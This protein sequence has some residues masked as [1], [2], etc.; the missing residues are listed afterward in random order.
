[1]EY[2]ALDS[3]K[4]YSFASIQDLDGKIRLEARIEHHPGA[5]RELLCKRETGSPVAVE[6]IGNW[7]WIISEIEEAGMIPK[8]VNAR[9]A[10]MM[11][12]TVN[13]TDRLDARGMNLLQ[14][15]GTLP[16]VW[17]PP[18]QLRD[19]RELFRTRMVLTQQ[20]TRMKNRIHATLAK[21]ALRVEDS[22]DA[23]NKKGRRELELKIQGLPPHTRYSTERV[24]EQLDSI[25]EQITLFE[26]RMKE[27]FAPSEELVFLM[28]L[29]GVGFILSAVILSEVGDIK[30]FPS[31]IHFA[32]Y[33]GTA[34]RV[35]ASGGK[36]RLG[37]LRSDVNRYLKWAFIEAA[38]S[39]SV[40]RY[41]CSQRHVNQLYERVRSRRGHQTAVGAV[42]RHLA[43]ATFWMLKKREEYREPT[44]ARISSTKR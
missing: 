18:G 21:Y 9:R 10:K 44:R 3:H 25:Q 6:T 35:H 33:S 26:E 38:N 1:M 17:I 19:Q 5:I 34:P 13:K 4:R 29:P 2:I 15:S 37:Q 22:S 7:Y 8:L 14:R 30:R 40:N 36:V 39:I 23:F 42:A 24:L 31:A 11:L 32:S 16:T 43:E 41:R 12:A 20:R 27:V 28:T